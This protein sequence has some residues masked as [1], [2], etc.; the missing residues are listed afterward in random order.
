MRKGFPIRKER[1]LRL[2]R[3]PEA[4]TRA[5]PTSAVVVVDLLLSQLIRLSNFLCRGGK[6]PMMKKSQRRSRSTQR[7]LSKGIIISAETN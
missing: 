4:T 7:K 1:D 3:R 2:Y 5:I 6:E